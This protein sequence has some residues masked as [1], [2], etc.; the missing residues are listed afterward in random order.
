MIRN[1]S[2]SF[3]IYLITITVVVVAAAAAAV[4]FI[5]PAAF[6]YVFRST[7]CGKLRQRKAVQSP[8]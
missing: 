2:L 1:F 5:A 8:V 3:T 7:D 4:A 6:K